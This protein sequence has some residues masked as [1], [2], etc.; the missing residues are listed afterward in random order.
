[1]DDTAKPQKGELNQTREGKLDLESVLPKLSR[2]ESEE[3]HENMRQYVAFVLRV[4]ERLKHER[5]ANA[6]PP[7]ALTGSQVRHSINGNGHQN[8]SQDDNS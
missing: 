6:N 7:D 3:A 1:M 8:N 4:V 2:A 5:D